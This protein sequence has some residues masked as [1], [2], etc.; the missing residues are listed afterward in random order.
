MPGITPIP[1]V[2]D[3]PTI[4]TATVSGTTASVPFTA[5]V[6]GGTVTTFTATSTPGSITGTSATSPISVSGLTAST[7]YT[8]KVKGT[9][10]TATGPESAASN[11]VTP[12]PIGFNSIATVTVGVGGQSSISFTSIP[13]TYKHLQ[14]RG[15][16]RTNDAGQTQDVIGLR[17]N[18]DTTTANY[19]SHRIAADGTNKVSTTQASGTY[20]SS[21][22]GYAT[23][24]NASASMFGATIIDLY[25][26]TSTVKNKVGRSLAGDSQNNNTDNQ[27]I[28]GSSLYLST[29]AVTTITLVPIFASGF[30]QYTSFALYGIEGN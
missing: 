2:P 5:A 14:I 15:I 7:A 28:L 23:G 21:W 9:N 27:I 26:Y 13:Q 12:P 8:F 4:G 6:T 24:V 18:S 1:D 25:D 16:A 17:I 29:S 19:R 30:A 20:S 3:A 11:S 10:A 22:I